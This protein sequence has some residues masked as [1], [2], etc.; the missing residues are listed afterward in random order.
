ME[1]CSRD[2]PQD[3]QKCLAFHGHLCPGLVYGYLVARE[4]KQRLGLERACDEEVVACAENDSC[5]VDALQV[6]L[7][8]TAGKGNLLILPYG[9]SVYS[10]FHRPSRRAL[11]FVRTDAFRRVAR[12]GEQLQLAAPDEAAWDLLDETAQS[13]LKI[14]KAL[15]LLAQDFAAVFGVTEV[16]F[17]PP[18]RAAVAPSLPCEHCGELTM[19][20]K[21]A[22]AAE[23]KKRLCFPCRQADQNRF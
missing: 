15:N 9:K 4:A 5:A 6:L 8:T 12:Q 22:P 23:G 11:R 19:A 16:A 13:Q 18:P 17:L 3:L 1:E 21:L 14:R 7:G 2:L 10:I 20:D